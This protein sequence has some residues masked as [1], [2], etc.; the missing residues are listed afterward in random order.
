[1]NTH[2]LLVFSALS[3]PNV[4]LDWETTSFG[5]CHIEVLDENIGNYKNKGLMHGST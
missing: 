5:A 3:S 2:R 4:H 1:M